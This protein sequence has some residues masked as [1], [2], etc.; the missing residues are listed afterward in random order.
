[1]ATQT[2]GD[3]LTAL[4]IGHYVYA[5][6]SLESYNNKEE[7]EHL[8]PGRLPEGWKILA[9]SNDAGLPTSIK[10]D[11]VA[12]SYFNQQHEAL[13]LA[14]Q[15]T[16]VS[17][18]KNLKNINDI[19]NDWELFQSEIPS[20]LNSVNNYWEY[21]KGL[22]C[23][24]NSIS[25]KYV[26]LTG[27]SL[28]AALAE[29]A[30]AKLKFSSVTF[31]SPGTKEIFEKNKKLFTNYEEALNFVNDNVITYNAVPDII[32]TMAEHVGTVYTVYP[33]HKDLYQSFWREI[34][35]L[36]I[37][38]ELF[39][40]L[41]YSAL[42]NHHMAGILEQFDS[43][44]GYPKVNGTIPNPPVGLENG[45]NWYK[46]YDYNTYYWVSCFKHQ[47]DWW[48][49][50]EKYLGLHS[51]LH[52]TKES[53][54]VT[55]DSNDGGNV[56]W[57]TTNFD[58]V[59]RSGIGDDTY[60]LFGG[61]DYSYD[62]GGFDTYIYPVKNMGRNTIWDLDGNGMIKVGNTSLSGT[63]V[64]IYYS[65][66]PY[67]TIYDHVLITDRGS[68]YFL[69]EENN[70]LL[71]FTECN[72]NSKEKINNSITI[73]NY[74]WGDF[75]ITKSDLYDQTVLVGPNSKGTV[76]CETTAKKCIAVSSEGV[77]EDIFTLI[78]NSTQESKLVGS[79]TNKVNI[80]I[81]KNPEPPADAYNKLAYSLYVKNTMIQA[82]NI[83][84]GD[85]VDLT[86]FDYGSIKIGKQNGTDCY[87]DI[88]G[89]NMH[90]QT[91][92][93]YPYLDFTLLENNTIIMQNQ[94]MSKYDKDDDNSFHD[95]NELVIGLS[96]GVTGATILSLIGIC[97]WLKHHYTFEL[98]L[99]QPL[100]F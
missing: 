64:P 94:D 8:P 69:K 57:G 24:D 26:M 53:T 99:E 74:N 90:M 17:R 44:T 87:L 63:A 73:K 39:Y 40:A 52:S 13:I 37:M 65:S 35:F 55:I 83:K 41:Q 84:A 56:I 96:A 28:G 46:S 88:D 72:V 75:Q 32:N 91:N 89:S 38:D 97:I 70:D 6:L 85:V 81:L 59:V 14:I 54:G 1:M 82:T 60:Y 9:S 16:N 86:D 25:V 18:F 3:F 23:S 98:E 62:K 29:L 10:K 45:Y 100:I 2:C 51:Q 47:N 34:S 78:T 76:A 43:S 21:T 7:D 22:I 50:I 48:D 80:K 30:S 27:H 12:K 4:H 20:E 67:L 71:I 79:M 92:I 77:Q 49:S 68:S 58:D 19:I 66:C 15:G 61:N 31:D 42:G 95:N 36:K 5:V 33:D 93:N 11:F